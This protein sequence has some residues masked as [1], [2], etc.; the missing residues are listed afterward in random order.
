MT[1]SQSMLKQKRLVGWN[2]KPYYLCL[3]CTFLLSERPIFRTNALVP[4]SQRVPI[5]K[6]SLSDDHHYILSKSIYLCIRALVIEIPHRLNSNL[7]QPFHFTR[8]W[9]I[10]LTKILILFA[11]Q[12]VDF[13]PNFRVFRD[14]RSTFGE[15]SPFSSPS[16]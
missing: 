11:F 15:N 8:V 5:R 12:L 6:V 1:K 10:S 13:P 9:I 4:A 14:P 2:V 7:A 16:T 3:L